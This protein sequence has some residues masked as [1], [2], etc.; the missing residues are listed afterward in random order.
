MTA[1]LKILAG[2]ALSLVLIALAPAILQSYVLQGPHII[3]LM[4]EK[5]GQVES[6]S[7][8]HSV[9]FYYIAQ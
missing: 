2:T 4:T 6:L 3:Q 7:V 5:L 1:V 9:I 8:Y